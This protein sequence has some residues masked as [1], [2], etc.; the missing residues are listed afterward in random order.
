MV[1]VL[2]GTRRPRSCFALGVGLGVP[3]GGS[4]WTPSYSHA[5]HDTHTTALWT[6]L[7]TQSAL[8][9]YSKPR[10]E[11]K[12]IP[13]SCDRSRSF[14]NEL[15]TVQYRYHSLDFYLA[16]VVTKKVYTV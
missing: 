15:I 12:G 1:P 8:L 2:P 6:Q 11:R 10:G 4:L 13:R 5:A 3:I 16:E 9:W 14:P 7:W